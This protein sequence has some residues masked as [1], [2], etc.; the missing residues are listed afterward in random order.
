MIYFIKTKYTNLVKIGYT[1]KNDVRTR[2]SQL[3]SSTP[4]ELEVMKTIDGGKTFEKAFHKVFKNDNVRG[5]W[6]NLGPKLL[7]FIEG[8]PQGI[9]NKSD[10]ERKERDRV[11]E[12]RMEQEEK[13][14]KIKRLKARFGITR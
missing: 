10:I 1:S 6:F 13:I 4:S 3:Q 11:I 2:L 8:T 7:Q 9:G 5:E 12:F 14:N